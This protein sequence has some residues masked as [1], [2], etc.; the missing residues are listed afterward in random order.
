MSFSTV[1]TTTSGHVVKY[2]S[3]DRPTTLYYVDGV[4]VRDRWWNLVT[5]IE[6]DLITADRRIQEILALRDQ[7]LVLADTISY[8]DLPLFRI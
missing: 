7:F 6:S 1:R 2:V 3:V 5:E 4:R 8:A